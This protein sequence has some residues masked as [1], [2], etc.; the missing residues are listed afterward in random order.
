VATV[1]NKVPSTSPNESP[2]VT[3]CKIACIT[4]DNNNIEE[5]L[6][7]EIIFTHLIKALK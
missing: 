4:V 6:N 2:H 1:L 7:N 5:Q 3:T